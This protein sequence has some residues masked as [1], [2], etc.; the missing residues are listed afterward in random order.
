[1]IDNFEELKRTH[2]ELMT[3]YVN[4]INQ[5]TKFPFFLDIYS[6]KSSEILEKYVKTPKQKA[7]IKNIEYIFDL[8]I[9]SYRLSTLRYFVKLFIESHIKGKLNLIGNSYILLAQ[10]IIVDEQS[11]NEYQNWLKQAEEGT[12]KFAN[13]LSSFQSISGFIKVSWPLIVGLL[14]ANFGV[15]NIY[16]AIIKIIPYISITKFSFLLFIL[17][18][19]IYLASFIVSAFIYKRSLFHSG[20]QYFFLE[21]RDT[22]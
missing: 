13:T 15:D 5:T 2:I 20:S 18:I 22:N 3:E 19:F 11:A 12:R 14:V 4:L 10:T 17:I 16:Q 21:L 9:Y 8:Y 7:I 1:M 6:I